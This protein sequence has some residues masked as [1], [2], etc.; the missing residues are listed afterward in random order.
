[1]NLFPAS[2]KCSKTGSSLKFQK[3]K[4]NHIPITQC[5]SAVAEKTY[6]YVI[7]RLR[8]NNL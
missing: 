5:K 8:V 7:P 3:S 1:M 4:H 2:E 6:I